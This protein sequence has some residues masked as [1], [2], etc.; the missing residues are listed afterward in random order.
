MDRCASLM[1]NL[2]RLVAREVCELFR[3]ALECRFV[4]VILRALFRFNLVFLAAKLKLSSRAQ[5]ELLH[6][7]KNAAHSY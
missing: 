7:E 5:W 1:T 3:N 4:S 2:S 6:Q